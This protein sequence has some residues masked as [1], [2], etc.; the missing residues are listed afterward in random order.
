ML[1]HEER[2]REMR[3][4]LLGQ[5]RFNLLDSL[6][7]YARGSISSGTD[8]FEDGPGSKLEGR[9]DLELFL[10]KLEKKVDFIISMLTDNLTR[11]SYLHKAA[12]LDLSES[13]VQI[14][15]PIGL[16]LG[17]VL[18]IG[19]ILPN[20]PYRTL[21]LAGE[22]IWEKQIEGRGTEIPNILGIRFL[23][24]LPEDQDDIVHWIFQRQ[25]EEIRRAKDQDQE[26]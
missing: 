14:Q 13:G 15:S 12:L 1:G 6:H 18:E 8:L 19:L 10:I 23:D 21:D 9:G 4:A 25:R 2:R 24:I 17:Q 22:V 16:S 20:R 26:Y 3:A 5:I 11:K 7:G